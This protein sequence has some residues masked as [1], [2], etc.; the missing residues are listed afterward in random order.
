MRKLAGVAAVL[1]MCSTVSFAQQSG[2]APEKTQKT[3]QTKTAARR[4]S[5]ANSNELPANAVKIQ[6]G[7]YQVKDA[8]GKTWI[9]SRTPFGWSK[10]DEAASKESAR[11]SETPAFRAV[12]VEGDKVKFERETPF[13]KSTWTKP[14]ADLTADEK[15]AYDLK[16]N[17]QSEKQ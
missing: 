10:V 5:Q 12:S 16:M 9:Y 2:R 1:A 4:G 15:A 11:A 17:A 8:K 6:E 7:V 13:G 3:A 14:I